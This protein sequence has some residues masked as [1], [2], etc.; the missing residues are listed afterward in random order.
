MIVDAGFGLRGR[1]N[2]QVLKKGKVCRESG[3]HKNLI[4]DNFFNDL[5]NPSATT[6]MGSTLSYQHVVVGT[7]ST[8]P[9]PTQT[10]LA[11]YLA[12]KS[13][14]DGATVS[15]YLGVVNNKAQ[16]KWSRTWTFTES[17]VTGNVSE[18]G[19][20]NASTPGT[21]SATALHTRALVLDV[22]SN[23]TSIPVGAGEQLRV[24]HEFLFEV[25][26]TAFSQNMSVTTGGNTTNHTVEMQWTNITTAANFTQFILES[27]IF[28]GTG[29]SAVLAPSN[30]Y[31]SLT[32]GAG[33]TTP[34]VGTGFATSAVKTHTQPSGVLTARLNWSIPSTGGNATGGIGGMHVGGTSAGN[35]P[36]CVKFTPALPK[37]SL[38]K[39]VIGFDFTY[40]R[41]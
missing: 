25:D 11:T 13:T 12:G 15:T 37:T 9:A 35:A 41:L 3:F 20:K 34:T 32:F 27:T 14:T 16:Y 40:T 4:L 2:V 28:R 24:I 5:T 8:A 23:P 10:N 31:S 18:V 30:T 26:L 22:N 36:L 21:L 17:A 38:N 19:T 1:Q 6:T 7:G 33:N 39:L 29:G